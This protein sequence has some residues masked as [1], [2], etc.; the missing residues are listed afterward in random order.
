MTNGLTRY[1]YSNQVP[2]EG[3]PTSYSEAVSNA[4]P[5]FRNDATNPT[6]TT[7]AT[8]IY[9]TF[10]EVSLSSDKYLGYF[11]P[12]V[13]G[14]WTFNPR[15]ESIYTYSKNAV[16]YIG[17]VGTTPEEIVS[18]YADS[19][20]SG[21]FSTVPSNTQPISI[22]YSS[23]YNYIGTIDIPFANVYYP[24]VLYYNYYQDETVD[25][26]LIFSKPNS[27]E[28]LYDFTGYMYTS[29]PTPPDPTPIPIP[30]PNPD[31][32]VIPIPISNICF[33]AKTPVSTDQ[34]IVA[35]EKINPEIHT[36]DN[37]KIVGIT[38]TIHQNDY[39]VCF[40]KHALGFNYPSAQ[41]TMTNDHKISYQGKMRKASYFLDH[42][43]KVR[44]ID[45]HG[46]ILYNVL[47]EKHEKIKINHL[48]CETLHPRNI[49]AKLY[50]SNLDKNYKNKI[51]IMLNDS[52]HKNDYSI[53][54]KIIEMIDDGSLD[55]EDEDLMEVDDPIDEDIKPIK[56]KQEKVEIK[57]DSQKSG[58]LVFNCFN[59]TNLQTKMEK[60]TSKQNSNNDTSEIIKK[61]EILEQIKKQK[62]EK[63]EKE[64]E[65]EIKEQKNME[66]INKYL[67]HV[68]I[69]KTYKRKELLHKTKTYKNK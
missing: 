58:P 1:Y 12:D 13:T 66:L 3:A 28:S 10:T 40:E 50:R 23:N 29:K 11:Y 36:I 34:G 24:F 46:E 25:V 68:T 2:S 8:S 4:V 61:K 33:P 53:Y 55:F 45:Y 35:I 69:T 14:T 26:E 48:L 63:K 44:K 67:R 19:T 17:E 60:Y 57:Y 39:L 7:V 47:M 52:I 56:Y 6:S 37:K 59:N 21:N 9:Y 64:I 16:L 65:K 62:E 32:D 30:V 41:T 31:P 5:F 20:Y 22:Y 54:K 49:I 43:E 15:M 18:T 27:S 51:T 38:Q 42:F